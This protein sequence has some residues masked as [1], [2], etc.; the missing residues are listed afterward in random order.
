MFNLTLAA[1]TSVDR[2]VLREDQQF[3]QRIRSYS[4]AVMVAGQWQPFMDGTG[5]G[6]RMIMVAK[7][8]VTVTAVRLTVGNVIATPHMLQFAAFAPCSTPVPI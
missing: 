6:N 2:V 7:A 1:P 3:G 5:V 4:V 8:P